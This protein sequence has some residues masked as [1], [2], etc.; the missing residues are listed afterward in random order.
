MDQIRLCEKKR[1]V[2]AGIPGTFTHYILEHD[3]VQQHKGLL[4]PTVISIPIEQIRNTVRLQSGIQRL[5]HLSTIRI[6]SANPAVPELVIRNIRNGSAFEEGLK[7]CRR[8]IQ[9]E[10]EVAADIQA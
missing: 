9:L 1:W 3:T 2:L 5:F 7:L 4:S 6:A 10:Q 8:R